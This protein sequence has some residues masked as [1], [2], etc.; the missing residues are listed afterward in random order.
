[1]P[2]ARHIMSRL[3]PDISTDLQKSWVKFNPGLQ[4]EEQITVC[5][6]ING[7]S[8]GIFN[9]NDRPDDIKINGKLSVPT[10]AYSGNLNICIVMDGQTTFLDFQP[11]Y[12][13]LNPLFLDLTYKDVD[14]TG[15]DPE[16]LE[17]YYLSES[18]LMLPAEYESKVIDFEKGTLKVNKVKIYHFSRYGWAK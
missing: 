14:L 6:S 4:I 5:K 12:D 13:F 16:K 8:G 17:F 7:E 3:G 11:S 9:F 1:M 2:A 15:V 18:G 10:G